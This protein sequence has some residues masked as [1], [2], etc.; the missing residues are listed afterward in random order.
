ML[1]MIRTYTLFLVVAVTASCGTNPNSEIKKLPTP[2]ALL[3]SWI[4]DC[5]LEDPKKSNSK[6]VMVS[7]VISEG[8]LESRAQLF[9]DDQCTVASKPHIREF[10]VA[11]TFTGDMK[12]TPFGSA[13]HVNEKLLER[14]HDGKSLSKGVGST[15]YDIILVKGNN[16]YYGRP[17]GSN[18]GRTAAKR[19]A[20]LITESFYTKVD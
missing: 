8:L 19:H 12:E 4:Q 5:Q 3:G 7:D 18:N 15:A 10:K 2:K 20:E 6:F 16:L 1:S 9:E 17:T 13:F 14:K 11:L